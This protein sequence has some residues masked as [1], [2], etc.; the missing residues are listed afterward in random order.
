MLYATS[1]NFALTISSSTVQCYTSFNNDTAQAQIKAETSAIAGAIYIYNS[2]SGITASNNL[3]RYCYNTWRGAIYSIGKTV[4]T[5][6]N[7]Q[8][9]QNSALF[10]GAMYSDS[11]TFTMTDTRLYE[12]QAV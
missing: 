11:S 1:K 9:Y 7:S 12:N 10:A 5:E 2:I 8:Y 4:M 3:Y 6:T